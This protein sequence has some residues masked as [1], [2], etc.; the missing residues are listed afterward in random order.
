MDELINLVTQKVGIPA[1]KA[2]LAVTTVLGYLK[3]KLPGS[4]A[5]QIDS[6]IG[7]AS[8]GGGTGGLGDMAKRAGGMFG[9]TEDRPGR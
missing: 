5:G 6:L 7:G 1:D 9:G 8:A 4:M 2:Q 3:G